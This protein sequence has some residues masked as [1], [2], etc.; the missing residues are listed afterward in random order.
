MAL[1]IN[2]TPQLPTGQQLKPIERVLD[3][4]RAWPCITV[5]RFSFRRRRSMVLLLVT[6]AKLHVT[7]RNRFLSASSFC[8]TD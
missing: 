7:P 2:V 6:L 3:L 5:H 8:Q 1:G 4:V